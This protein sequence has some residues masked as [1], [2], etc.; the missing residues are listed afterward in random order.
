MEFLGDGELSFL[1]AKR[2]DTL[3]PLGPLYAVCTPLAD[4]AVEPIFLARGFFFTALAR[5]LQGMPPLQVLAFHHKSAFQSAN[6]IPTQSS[7]V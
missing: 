7:T 5:I 1:R 2:G 6:P 3:M 4:A